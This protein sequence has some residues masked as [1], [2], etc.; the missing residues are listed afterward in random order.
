MEHE[1]KVRTLQR[2]WESIGDQACAELGKTRLD[3]DEVRAYISAYLDGIKNES[4]FTFWYPL[5]D[6]E[7]QALLRDAFPPGGYGRLGPS[8]DNS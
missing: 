5:P 2:A 1:L 8:I 6:H 7:K 4:Y 3:A